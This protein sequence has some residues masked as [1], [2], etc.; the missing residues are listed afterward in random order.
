[1]SATISAVT[2]GAIVQIGLFAR[3]GIGRRRS[4]GLFLS[5]ASAQKK[6]NQNHLARRH[7][8]LGSFSTAVV[9][10]E[11]STMEGVLWI[12]RTSAPRRGRK[13]RGPGVNLR[14]SP[15]PCG[16]CSRQSANLIAGF[17][18]GH[19]ARAGVRGL[20]RG[21]SP[22]AYTLHGTVR[23]ARQV[24]PSHRTGKRFLAAGRT[25]IASLN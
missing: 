11:V 24:Q 14:F 3:R 22:D 1:M 12:H 18:A 6:R 5:S 21:V 19:G 4:F 7:N 25:N 20:R 23:R 8:V 16:A 17:L 10:K 15:G 9:A 13:K 2:R